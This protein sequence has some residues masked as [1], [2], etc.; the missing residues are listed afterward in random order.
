MSL[1]KEDHRFHFHFTEAAIGLGCFS[2]DPGAKESNNFD[3]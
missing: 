3:G 2:L 1:L